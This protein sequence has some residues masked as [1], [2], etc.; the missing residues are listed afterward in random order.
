ME[1]AAVL[2]FLKNGVKLHFYSL[3]TILDPKSLLKN[4]IKS[5]LKNKNT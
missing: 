2:S 5:L 1:Y 4:K 3:G